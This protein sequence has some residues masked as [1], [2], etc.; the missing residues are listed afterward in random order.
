MKDD[1][2]LIAPKVGDRMMLR[3]G[4]EIECFEVYDDHGIPTGKWREASQRKETAV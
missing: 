3:G 4:I 1:Q 2:A